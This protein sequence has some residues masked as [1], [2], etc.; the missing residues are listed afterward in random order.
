MKTIYL[1][2][3]AKSSWDYPHLAD[4]ERPLNERGIRSCDLMAQPILNSPCCFKQVYCS[5]AVRAKLT[6]SL[7]ARALEPMQVDWLEDDSLYCFEHLSLLSWLAGLDDA[8]DEVVLV[9]HNP[10]FTDLC[11]AL[12]CENIVNIPTCGYAK[13]VSVSC[14]NWQSVA[15]TPFML[16][17][18]LTPKKVKN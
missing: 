13:L 14:S 7:I 18:F 17:S 11:N 5:S 12:T 2:R 4:I 9:G 6:I 10:A 8:F 16:E 1:I 3:H 15:D